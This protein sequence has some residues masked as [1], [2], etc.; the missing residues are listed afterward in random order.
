[1]KIAPVISAALEI[2]L[3]VVGTGLVGHFMKELHDDYDKQD[4]S[5]NLGFYGRHEFYL[6]STSLGVIIAICSIVEAI[7]G[8]LEK[9]GGVLVMAVVHALWA[10]QL[11]VATALLAK[12]LTTYEDKGDLPI[13]LCDVYDKSDKDYQCSELIGGV[14]CGF[15]AAVIFI[16]DAVLYIILPSEQK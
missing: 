1:M 14:A 12:V 3:L 2:V 5:Y 10:F 16:I 15:I 7:T 13:S 11:V 4:E 6:F 8:I 9:K